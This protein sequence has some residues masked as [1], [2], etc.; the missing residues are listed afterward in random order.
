MSALDDIINISNKAP[1]PSSPG[2]SSP[3]ATLAKQVT[4]RTNDEQ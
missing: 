4:I 2:L 3:G 1:S